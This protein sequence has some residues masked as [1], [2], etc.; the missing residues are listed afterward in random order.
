MSR[1]V[2]Q[3]PVTTDLREKAEKEASKQGFSSLQEVIRVFLTK[4]AR[5]EVKVGFEE[6]AVQLSPRAAKRYNKMI[7]DV[8]TGK[9][10][11]VTVNSVEE[12]ME[13]LHR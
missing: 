5:E 10:K 7:E 6:E 12:L 11:T 13:H 2:I 9:V 3:V 8:K 4:L 1:T